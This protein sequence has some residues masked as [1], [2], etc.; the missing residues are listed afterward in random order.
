MK[1]KISIVTLLGAFAIMIAGALIM[2]SCE[3]PAGPAGAAGAAGADGVDGINGTDGTDGVAGNAV[4][5][6]CHTL[7]VKATMM[8]EWETSTHATGGHERYGSRNGCAKCHAHEGFVET[9]WTGMDTTAT[10]V[11]LPQKI[12]CK[13]CHDFHP[14]L[15]FENEANSAIRTMEEVELMTGGGMVGFANNPESNL[16]VNCHQSRHAP[17]DDSDGTALT[18]VY[19]RFGPH[20]GPQ[21][22]FIFGGEGYEFGA[23]LSTAGAHQSGSSCVGCHMAETA[24][25]TTGGHTFTPSLDACLT[26]HP[27]ATD[28]DVNGGVTEIAGLMEDLEA[29][30]DAAGMLE[31]DGDLVTGAF[32]SA[33]S[34]G[35]AWNYI[36]IMEDASSGIHN[37]AYAKAL[38]NNSINALG[39]N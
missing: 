13:T 20:H 34:V 3:G 4:C 23:T 18:E 8:A 2:S 11:A 15:D 38:L 22:N 29:A 21:G 27:D 28:F 14:S 5:L 31:D 1:K 17:P 7:D 24:A 35:A 36:L 33:D 25:D 26:C 19:N 10:G 37:P 9:T 39:A 16:C 30:L 6:Q 12:Q 32:Y